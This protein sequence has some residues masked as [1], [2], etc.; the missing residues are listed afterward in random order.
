MTPSKPE[1]DDSAG[2]VLVVLDAAGV[3][4]NDPAGLRVLV[5]L[6]EYAHQ[7]YSS[8]GDLGETRPR[9]VRPF[10]VVLQMDE[11]EAERWAQA[12]AEIEELVVE[13]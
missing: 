11:E 5:N 10:H 7:A 9:P 12:G 6:L 13:C 8:S 3:L 2:L 4:V 1:D